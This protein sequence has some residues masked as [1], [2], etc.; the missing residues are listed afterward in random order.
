MS[1]ENEFEAPVT[2]Q[3]A[4]ISDAYYK[5][6]S[7]DGV[8][9]KKEEYVKNELINVVYYLD[10]GET[11]NQAVSFLASAYQPKYGFDIRHREDYDIYKKVTRRAYSPSGVFDDYTE[12]LLYDAQNRCVYERIESIDNGILETTVRKYFYNKANEEFMFF[13]DNS[14]A[15][16]G[17]NGKDSP[18]VPENS[19]CIGVDEFSTYFPTFL[20]NFPYYI[21]SNP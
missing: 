16:L 19:H 20:A 12:I 14:G 17:V 13:Y 15:L 10:V 11:E 7:V 9:K 4:E 2:D 1:F 8:I 6:F 21:N 5:V 18:F 3:E